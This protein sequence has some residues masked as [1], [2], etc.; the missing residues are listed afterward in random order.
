MSSSIF[1]PSVPAITQVSFSLNLMQSLSSLLC[2]YKQHYWMTKRRIISTVV[3][4]SHFIYFLF[5]RVSTKVET[6]DA[7][8]TKIC[9]DTQMIDL[10]YFRLFFSCFS[11]SLAQESDHYCFGCEKCLILSNWV[12][13]Q[14]NSNLPLMTCTLSFLSLFFSSLFWYNWLSATC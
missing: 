4:F 13:C 2:I 8:V 10:V 1:I 9:S 11:C 12:A 3:S 5:S 14:G 7:K 6:V